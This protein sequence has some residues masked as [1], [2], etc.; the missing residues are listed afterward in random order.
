MANICFTIYKITANVENSEAYKQLKSFL[1]SSEKNFW[2]GSLA[3]HF[4][5]DCESLKIDV[6]GWA[7]DFY[8]ENGV[9]TLEVESKW[10]PNEELFLV[11]NE[12]YDC[13]LSVSW[14][15]EE[16]GCEI[17]WIHDED[18]YFPERYYVD[19]SGFDNCECDYFETAKEVIDYWCKLTGNKRGRK[20]DEKMLEMIEYWEYEDDDTF[21]NV[22]EFEVD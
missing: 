1:D 3:K 9:I 2:L 18:D 21:F 14:R 16:P 11:I 12:K 22:H 7:I 5:I 17:F 15:A 10:S 19:C 13:E 4:D 8:E 6:R 20:S